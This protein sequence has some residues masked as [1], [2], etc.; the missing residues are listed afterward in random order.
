MA[1]HA[2]IFVE[3]PINVFTPMRA[4]SR[5][6]PISIGTETKGLPVFT[7]GYLCGLEWWALPDLC[8]TPAGYRAEVSARFTRIG[9]SAQP[10]DVEN[11]TKALSLAR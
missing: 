3:P 1:A 10:I 11:A 6:R 5:R 9:A 4:T 8:R 2:S 7:L